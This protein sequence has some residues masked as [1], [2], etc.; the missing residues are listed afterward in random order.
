MCEM[1]LK[2]RLTMN[3]FISFS[4]IAGKRAK[5]TDVFMIF[6][7]VVFW[8]AEMY[9]YGEVSVT[10]TA[11]LLF[12]VILFLTK[13]LWIKRSVKRQYKNHFSLK[14]DTVIEFYDDH[15]V[16]KSGGGETKIEYEDHFPFEAFIS[17]LETNEHYLFFTSPAEALLV[18]KRA[19]NS[20]EAQKTDNLIKNIFADRYRKLS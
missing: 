7:L 6:A 19:M 11:M 9:F 15:I 10:I 16:G 20:E 14:G 18:P 13:P 4:S 17:V 12:V 8:A 5:K 1:S 2:F 3:D